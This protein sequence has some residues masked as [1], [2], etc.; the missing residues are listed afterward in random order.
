SAAAYYNIGIA[1]AKPAELGQKSFH[2]AGYIHHWE[3]FHYVLGSKYFPELGYDS[4]YTASV[5]AERESHPNVR[6]MSEVRDLRTNELVPLD[7][8]A[9]EMR[10]IRARF[11]DERWASFVADNA[12]F[13]DRTGRDYMRRIRIDHGYNPTPFWTYVARLIDAKQPVT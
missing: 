2:G 10:R 3:T 13:I 11:T 4:L 12:Y 6:P 8:L 9:P 5:L 1:V 7:R